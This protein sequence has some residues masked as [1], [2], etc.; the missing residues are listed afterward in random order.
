MIVKSVP[1][2]LNS[3]VARYARMARILQLS[4]SLTVKFRVWCNS[5]GTVSLTWRIECEDLTVTLLLTV[6]SL[7]RTL[8][9]LMSI[10]TVRDTVSA[11]RLLLDMIRILRQTVTLPV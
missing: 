4:N 6:N 5:K 7:P 11:A 8:S 10:L 1:G 2:N 9:S 3:K